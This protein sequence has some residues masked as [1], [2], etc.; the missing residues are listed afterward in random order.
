MTGEY[1]IC[2]EGHLDEQWSPYLAGLTVA[3]GFSKHGS[4]VTTL[5]GA[6]SDQAALYG[7]LVKIRDIGL[8]IV[9]VTRKGPST[10]DLK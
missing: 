1:E 5:S 10:G 6:I 9:A 3:H 8:P 7:A 4:P 2:V